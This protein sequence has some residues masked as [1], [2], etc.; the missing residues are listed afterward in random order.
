MKKMHIKLA[1]F[2]VFSALSS[3]GKSAVLLGKVPVFWYNG[4]IRNR[5][6]K[7]WQTVLKI[8]SSMS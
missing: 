5:R 7:Q 1:F 2:S 8:S 6:K 4:N 3:L